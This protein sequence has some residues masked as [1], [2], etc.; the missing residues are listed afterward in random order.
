MVSQK[1]VA[2]IGIGGGG[3][4]EIP[5]PWKKKSLDERTFF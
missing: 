2:N 4:L 3:A 5:Q 1:N